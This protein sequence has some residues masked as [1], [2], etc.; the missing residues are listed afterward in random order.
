MR[1]YLAMFVKA[2]I[3]RTLAVIKE[4]FSCS[5]LSREQSAMAKQQRLLVLVGGGHAHI[6]VVASLPKAAKK[7]FRCVLISDTPSAAYSGLVP[8]VVAGLSP[9]ENA[10]VELPALAKYHD[11][12]FLH[13]RVVNVDTEART[14]TFIPNRGGAKRTLLYDV[15]SLDVGSTTVG[16]P[17]L[18]TSTSL[19]RRT[20]LKPAVIYT[21]PISDLMGSIS[22]FETAA[23]SRLSNPRVVIAGGGPAGIELALALDA[24]LQRALGKCDV[25]LISRS[26]SFADAVGRAAG[27]AALTELKARG[28]RLLL[29]SGANAID[30]Q[31]GRLLMEN[32]EPDVEFDCLIVATGAASHKWL[33][34]STNL[35][36]H[37]GWVVVGTD[38]RVKGTTNV[39]A[40]G[41]C[42]SFGATFGDNF[43]PKAGVYA[44]REGPILCHN[45]SAI[46]RGRESHSM[47]HF[48]PQKSFLSLLST[49][50]G[51]GIGSKY[52]LVFTGTWVYRLK[53]YIDEAWQD[54]FRIPFGHENGHVGIDDEFDGTP[55]EGAAILQAAEDVLVCD[56]F[57][58]QLG[59]LKRMDRDQGFREEL[60][61]IATRD[62]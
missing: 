14:I 19:R 24:R 57:E 36:L 9:E 48:S 62:S 43:P 33:S 46:L 10:Y 8:A 39:F 61:S 30:E 29:G 58:R 37:N 40:A 42:V 38:L 45:I 34:T 3:V 31:G 41:D 21:R 28:V 16:I 23:K 54:K 17:T 4:A 20:E 1:P 2:N 5:S 6:Q 35:P 25:T 13:A 15:L 7:D 51:R 18:S 53:N 27:N 11:F 26:E 22:D 56:S 52:G 49:G 47:K 50:D 60:L 44:V 12:L 32:G 55:L 59:V